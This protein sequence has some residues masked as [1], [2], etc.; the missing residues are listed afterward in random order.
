M[1]KFAFFNLLRRKSRTFLSIFMIAVG[2]LSII[3]LVSLVDGLLLDVQSATS[4]LQGIMVMQGD[5]GPPFSQVDS[6]LKQEIESISGVDKVEPV[7]LQL[8]NGWLRNYH[9]QS[10]KKY[11]IIIQNLVMIEVRLLMHSRIVNSHQS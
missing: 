10:L 2:V 9:S 3:S 5:F 4:S 8:L 6:D 1:L 7:I 11:S